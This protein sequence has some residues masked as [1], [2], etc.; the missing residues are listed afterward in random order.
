MVIAVLAAIMVP[1]TY[2]MAELGKRTQCV[3][4]L[5]GFSAA[6]VQFAGENRG[7]LP[8]YS[9]TSY[10]YKQPI[11]VEKLVKVYMADDPRAV[12][13]PGNAAG[14]PRASFDQGWMRYAYYGGMDSNSP[15]IA[16]RYF[17]QWQAA[18]LIPDVSA[19]RMADS[20]L[21]IVMSDVT[22]KPETAAS[23]A[24]INHLSRKRVPIGGNR[25]H[26]DGHVTFVAPGNADVYV[27]GAKTLYR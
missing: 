6:L 7:K 22:T 17:E 15:A 9:V 12:E 13:C 21:A 10:P 23:D 8:Q 4:K 25:L 16:K 11:F 1:M 19:I 3:V 2:R 26:L 24:D 20:P 5:R 18:G 27:A 14:V